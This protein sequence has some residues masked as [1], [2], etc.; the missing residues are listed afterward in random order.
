MEKSEVKMR[1]KSILVIDSDLQQSNLLK[2]LLFEAGYRVLTAADPEA[3]YKNIEQQKPDL[4]IADDLM[5]CNCNYELC[6]EMRANS[7]LN[8]IPLLILAEFSDVRAIIIGLEYGA[9]NFVFKPF[10]NQV[11]LNQIC[12]LIAP[13][14]LNSRERFIQ[15]IHF[16]YE[17]KEHCIRTE[18]YRIIEIL[19]SIYKLAVKKNNDLELHRENLEEEV[20]LKNSNLQDEKNTRMQTESE[21]LKLSNLIDQAKSIIVITDL[22]GNIEYV[23]PFFEK[24]TGYSF[25]EIKGKN[26][27]I[28]KSGRHEKVFYQKLWDTALAGKEWKG[29]FINRN[30]KG[31]LLYENA[32]IFSIKNAQGKITS[33]A[34]IAEDITQKKNYEFKLEKLHE[35]TLKDIEL[36]ASVQSYL[37]PKWIV[38]ENNLSVASVYSPSSNI[39][40]DLYDFIQVSPSEY[41]LYMG[42]IS[43]HGVQAAL[44]MTAVK[45]TI[46]MLINIEAENIQPARI[47]NKLND[48]I[49]KDFFQNNY[50]TIIFCLIDLRKN[51]IRFL[52]AGHPA[53][54][55]Y[56]NLNHQTTIHDIG[57]SIPIGWLETYQ[58]SQEEEEFLEINQNSTYLFYTD[59]LFEC[60]N[61]DGIELGLQGFTALLKSNKN[62]LDSTIMPFIIKQL[63]IDN[64]YDLSTDDFTLLSLKLFDDQFSDNNLFLHFKDKNRKA[65]LK[66][67]E[68][69]IQSKFPAGD[70]RLALDSIIETYFHNYVDVYNNTKNDDIFM[71]ILIDKDIKLTIWNKTD[72]ISLAQKIFDK[73]SQINHI[74]DSKFNKYPLDHKKYDDIFETTIKINIIQPLPQG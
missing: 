23:N 65:V 52:N 21:L 68:Q 24:K 20:R 4:I 33:L 42:D 51:Q 57:S 32:S 30:K 55:E 72:S 40:G 13:E 49:S 50:M 60:L 58:Y 12:A 62:N 39:G 69:F 25:S 47:I 1:D 37:L 5:L 41:V 16:Q 59:G 10:N 3:A 31:E 11:L 45:S 61:K 2:T 29:E 63:L 17:G 28:L 18:P 14:N 38:H 70:T 46:N 27:S 6:K 64:H 8:A 26:T 9:S 35:S 15:E 34:K 48:I 74:M 7:E 36:A 56:D 71:Q 67:A 66:T 44:I 54:I 73:Y 43:G 19:L 22:K 53:I